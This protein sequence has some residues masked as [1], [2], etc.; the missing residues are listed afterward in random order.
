MTSFWSELASPVAGV[1]EANSFTP[2]NF[3]QDRTR[4]AYAF[5]F[6]FAKL[7]QPKCNLLL[8]NSCWDDY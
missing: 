2:L 1:T 3:N 4:V 5:A 8:A 7:N 6:A